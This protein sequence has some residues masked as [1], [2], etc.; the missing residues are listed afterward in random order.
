M[1]VES[2]ADLPRA[3]VLLTPLRLQILARAR[4]PCSASEIALELGLP[5][6]KV[7]Y[8]VRE[9]AR[10]RFLARAGRRRKRGLFEQRYRA[11][12]DSYLLAPA[13]LGP[14]QADLGSVRDRFGLAYLL[15]LTARVQSELAQAGADAAEQGKR[16][17]TLALDV[18]LRFETAEQRERFTAALRDAVASVVAEHASPARRTDGSDGR[19]RPF[20]LTLTC[21]PA[22]PGAEHG[23]GPASEEASNPEDPEGT[24]ERA[25]E[26]AQR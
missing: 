14:L 2:I 7:N 12:A 15:A 21:H 4:T 19:G 1:E 9:L 25:Q 22:P 24:Q 17:A 13:L 18:D 20:R 8:H 3:G 11:T 23:S 10:A 16:L 26:G 5:R 6:Q